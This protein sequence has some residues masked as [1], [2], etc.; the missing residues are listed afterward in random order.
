MVTRSYNEKKARAGAKKAILVQR[1]QTPSA[2]KGSVSKYGFMR[3]SQKTGDEEA[4]RG[5]LRGMQTS[6]QIRRKK[7]ITLAPTPWDNKEKP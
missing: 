5:A 6:S 4:M 2:A 1:A 7:P 3:S